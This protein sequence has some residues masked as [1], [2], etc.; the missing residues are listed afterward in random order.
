MSEQHFQ[1][2]A[3]AV[4]PET[5]DAADP[6]QRRG[7]LATAWNALTALVGGIMGLLPHLLHHVG[8]LGG[9]VL[10]TGATGNVLFA[11]LGLVF[12][13][14]LLRRLYRRFGTWK[15][16]VLALG[17]F[18]LMFSLSAFVIGPAISNDD[19]NPDRDRTPVQTPDPEEHEGHHGG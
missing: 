2:E 6:D 9:A 7:V 18:A 1:S 8:I 19:P 12:S 3:E 15:A 10:V 4:R 17:V 13:L 5:L 16:P 14:P 11:V